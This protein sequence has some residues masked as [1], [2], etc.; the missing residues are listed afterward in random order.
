MA[1]ADPASAVNV[2]GSF[3]PFPRVVDVKPVA[4][5]IVVDAS[6]FRFAP[7]AGGAAAFGV[8]VGEL[9]KK[10]VPSNKKASL[11]VST[12]SAKGTFVLDFT[13]SGDSAVQNRDAVARALQSFVGT[14]RVD[15]RAGPHI[16]VS[17]ALGSGIGVQA[18]G[19]G[20]AGRISAKLWVEMTSDISKDPTHDDVVLDAARTSV[21]GGGIL[22]EDE[23]GAVMRRFRKRSKQS[24]GEGNNLRPVPSKMEKVGAQTVR[25]TTEVKV[26]LNE[27]QINQLYFEYPSLRGREEEHVQSG[28]MTRE[29]F[30]LS[31]F[32]F[33]EN[34]NDASEESKNIFHSIFDDDKVL[35]KREQA[36]AQRLE[37]LNC[38][39]SIDLTAAEVPSA[40]Y[41]GPRGHGLATGAVSDRQRESWR[42]RAAAQGGLHAHHDNAMVSTCVSQTCLAVVSCL[43][44]GH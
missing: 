1:S 10:P 12:S 29:Q 11:Q 18:C 9:I 26:S 27:G 13:A 8:G 17:G 15:G 42:L 36:K 44:C 16:P 6:G 35:G 5:R 21:V 4:G 3:E 32:D 2:V 37:L 31:F 41:G 40:L 38:C 39:R 43:L 7:D 23:F 33:L 25:S 19:D 20:L 24:E 28:R 22:G 34:A 30:F 14:A